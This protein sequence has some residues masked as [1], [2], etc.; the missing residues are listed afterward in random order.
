MKTG[1]K[2]LLQSLRKL[3]NRFTYEGF[4]I[5]NEYLTRNE[6][7]LIGLI[8]RIKETVEVITY[9]SCKK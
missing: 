3:R 1:E 6:D 8:G 4:F 2:E 9:F 7:R 5:K